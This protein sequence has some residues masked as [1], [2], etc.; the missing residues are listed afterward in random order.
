MHKVAHEDDLMQISWADMQNTIGCFTI[1]TPQTSCFQVG[2]LKELG[3]RA[4]HDVIV[5]QVEV[6]AARTIQHEYWQHKNNH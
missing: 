5:L 1:E 2:F 6:F 4:L 3:Q